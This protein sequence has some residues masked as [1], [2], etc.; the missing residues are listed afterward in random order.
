YPD[1]RILEYG[2][3]APVNPVDVTA[4]GIG[5]NAAGDSGL[6]TTTHNNDLIFGANYVVTSTTSVGAGFTKRVITSPDGDIAEERVVATAGTYSATA[7][8][9]SAGPWVMQMV[10]FRG[11]LVGPP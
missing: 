11:A 4:A 9:T 2:G 7:P 6:A 8:L 5:T 3:L 10:A 1:V